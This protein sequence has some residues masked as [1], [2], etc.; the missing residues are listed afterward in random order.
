MI[1]RGTRRCRWIVHFIGVILCKMSPSKNK[2]PPVNPR[3]RRHN[4]E[5]SNGEMM[6]NEKCHIYS[7]QTRI[8]IRVFAHASSAEKHFIEMT[9]GGHFI[10]GSHL[11]SGC[12]LTEDHFITNFPH[13]MFRK[14]SWGTTKRA[15]T[16]VHAHMHTC[17]H[18]ERSPGLTNL[19]RLP[20]V[21]AFSLA[22]LSNVVG[23]GMNVNLRNGHAG[24][25][26]SKLLC[27][28]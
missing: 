11:L 9:E 23:C 6:Q 2:Y 20:Q 17:I 26:A 1:E 7:L 15:H 27:I 25:A 18:V 16:C 14:A 28:F 10:E 13:K 12:W 8:S 3:R 21:A 24:G 4:G 22:F 19:P 5:N